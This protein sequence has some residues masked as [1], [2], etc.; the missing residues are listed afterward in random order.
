MGDCMPGE[1]MKLDGMTWFVSALTPQMGWNSWN[2]FAR[3]VDEEKVKAAADEFISTGLAAHGYTYVNIDD[4][5]EGKR[6]ANG[7][8]TANEKF[9]D[10]Q[11]LGE[12]IHAK[13]LKFGIYS[14]PGPLTC[15]KFEASY[16]HEDQDAEQWAKWGVD[17]V[18]YDWCAMAIRRR[19]AGIHDEVEVRP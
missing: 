17:Y 8:I 18:K 10:M 4:C 13:G 5:W 11:G 6:D 2:V 16:Q 7:I 9:P 15:A 1:V 3:A 19:S 12:Y 14:S